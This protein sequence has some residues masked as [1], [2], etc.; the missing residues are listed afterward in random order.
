MRN[1]LIKTCISI[2]IP[3]CPVSVLVT[4]YSLPSVITYSSNQMVLC[5]L[6]VVL[7]WV[8]GCSFF[9]KFLGGESNGAGR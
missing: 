6:I 9:F 5:K 3:V 4:V 7:V 2:L 8:W 1:M